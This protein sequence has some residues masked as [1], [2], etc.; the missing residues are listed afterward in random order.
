MSDAKDNRTFAVALALGA[1]ACLVY[2]ALS[3]NWLV[4]A[5]A[6]LRFG[7]R[8]NVVCDATES[9][10]AMS[11]AALVDEIHRSD[12][13]AA[14]SGAFAPMGWATTVTMLLAALGLAGGAGLA[15]ANKRPVVPIAPTTIALLGIMVG[16]I[17]GCVFVA[18]KPSAVNVGVGLGFWLFGAGSV[19]GI[20]GA[21]LL[22][23]INRAPDPDLMDGAMNPDEF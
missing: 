12:A 3:H 19:A 14:A 16:L 7:L 4:D 20:G 17:T 13:L 11:N 18:T 5:T 21:Q 8:G 22:A 10:A 9:C 23:K 15:L 2:A 6:E 1:A